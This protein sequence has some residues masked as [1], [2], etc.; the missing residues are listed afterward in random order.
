MQPQ[1]VLCGVPILSLFQLVR[2]SVKNGLS[3]AQTISCHCRDPGSMW[4]LWWTD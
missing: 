4:D 2:P 1:Y 3:M